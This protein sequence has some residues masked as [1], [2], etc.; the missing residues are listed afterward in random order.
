M[1]FTLTSKAF[2]WVFFL[3]LTLASLSAA[4]SDPASARDAEAPPT[5]DV[6]GASIEGEWRLEPTDDDKARRAE[7]IDQATRSFNSRIR[8]RARQRLTER[9]A[10]QESLRIELDGQNV[11]IGSER[12]EVELELGG[13]P[14]EI[15]AEGGK[16][17]ISARL[18]GERLVVETRTGQ[19]QRTATY[20]ADGE[21]LR[22][23]LEMIGRRLALPL[24]LSSTYVRRK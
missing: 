13:A 7:A 20:V 23:E 22:V 11:T 1:R 8:N 21:L 12:S 5:N 24:E 9:T 17:R 18:D 10:P 3:S 14:V 19:G 16:A 15:S 6:A 2:G 4:A